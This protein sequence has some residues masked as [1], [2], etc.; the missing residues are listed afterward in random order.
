LIDLHASAELR[1]VTLPGDLPGFLSMPLYI[2][3]LFCIRAAAAAGPL[4]SL[5][6]L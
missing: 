4:Y 2:S 6:P 5:P 1:Q 3:P